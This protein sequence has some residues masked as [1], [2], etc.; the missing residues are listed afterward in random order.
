VHQLLDVG[1]GDVLLD[2]L[3]EDAAAELAGDRGDQE[4]QELLAQLGRNL[5]EHLVHL[6]GEFGVTLEVVLVVVAL[7]LLHHHVPLAPQGRHVQAVHGGEVGGVEARADQRLGLGAA[8]HFFRAV[9]GGAGGTH[10]LSS[11]AVCR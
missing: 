1:V 11:G 9:Q 10:G 2:L 4:V 7:V 8:R 3:V 6:F 5:R